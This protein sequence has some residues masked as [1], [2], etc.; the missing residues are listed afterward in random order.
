[1]VTF[2]NGQPTVLE[3]KNYGQPLNRITV[4]LDYDVWYIVEGGIPFLELNKIAKS[5]PFER[6]DYSIPDTFENPFK[7]KALALEL[8][9]MNEIYRP[10]KPIHFEIFTQGHIPVSSQ[11]TITIQE[12]NGG[13]MVWQNIPLINI[14]EP[15]IGFVDYTWSTGYDLGVPRI[16]KTGEYEMDVSWD[17]VSV[18]HKFQIREEVQFTFLKDMVPEYANDEDFL[19]SF[20]DDCSR[21]EINQILPTGDTERKIQSIQEKLK[22]N[23]QLLDLLFEKQEVMTNDQT[24][25]FS[26]DVPT[27]VIQCIK[28][29]KNNGKSLAED[30]A[31]HGQ[32]PEFD[33][34][35]L[36]REAE[37]FF[38]GHESRFAIK[39]ADFILENVESNNPDALVVKG[40]SLAR[41]NQYEEA[42]Q[43][44]KK[45]VEANPDLVK[46][47]YHM[48]RTLSA[49]DQHEKALQSFNQAIKIDS[50]FADA[51]IGKA[52]TL[53]TLER[54][55]EALENAEKAVQVKPD[56]PIYRNI[57]QT[58]LDVS[59]SQ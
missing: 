12:S 8:I 54:F 21:K 5:I 1:M 33:M 40:K 50:N 34:Q 35:L 59:E 43:T 57:Y 44:F 22:E 9:G 45:A 7:E 53:M 56:I 51:Y 37:I 20:E 31:S 48:G 27:E 4:Y 49:D 46:G 18:H 47:W 30:L 6:G 24:R 15:E 38:D 2:L 55:D 42:I 58:V 14:G 11:I 28:N 52:F 13:D 10:G 16:Y 41:L 25:T 36:Q 29:I 23:D 26:Y 39:T 3:K 17:D 19:L 32:K